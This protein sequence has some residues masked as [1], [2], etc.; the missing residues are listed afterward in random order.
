MKFNR[1]EFNLG[2]F[3][4]RKFTWSMLFGKDTYKLKAYHAV[5][6]GAELFGKSKGVL[7]VDMWQMNI[8]PQM[9][10]M[11]LVLQKSPPVL[12]TDDGK[13]TWRVHGDFP[14][15]TEIADDRQ[16]HTSKSR[17]HETDKL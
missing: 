17:E 11:N 12:V 4:N 7:S 9:P 10:L 15:I 13:W 3:L 14:V 16:I 6:W 5:H 1:T 2:M 8:L